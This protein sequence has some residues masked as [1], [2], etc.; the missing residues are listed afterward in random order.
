MSAV[1]N[2][3]PTLR[4]QPTPV[5]KVDSAYAVDNVI[6]VRIRANHV[7]VIDFGALPLPALVNEVIITD[8]SAK[9]GLTAAASVAAWISNQP[10]VAPSV[11]APAATETPLATQF[12][13][14]QVG[15]TVTIRRDRLTEIQILNPSS[16]TNDIIVQIETG[17]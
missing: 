10:G 8:V 9:M 1:P 6:Y 12:R 15:A 16:N 14:L 3:N 7:A 11:P 17:G 2:A 13:M 4:A 5:L